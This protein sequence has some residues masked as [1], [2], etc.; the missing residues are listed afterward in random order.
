MLY[1]GL[2]LAGLLLVGVW[3]GT[4]HL[5]HA[6]LSPGDSPDT[7]DYAP[8][9]LLVI[10]RDRGAS[11]FPSGPAAHTPAAK[12][13]DGAEKV[14][15]DPISITVGAFTLAPMAQAGQSTIFTVD[16]PTGQEVA[17]L[18]ALSAEPGVAAVS[19]DYRRHI[20]LTPDDPSFSAKQWNMR[21]IN[22]PLAWD[23]TTGSPK[24]IIAVAD[25]GVDGTHPDL[26][27]RLVG[28]INT[29][30]SGDAP[31][32]D[33]NGHGTHVAS[34]AAGTGNDGV[35]IAGVDWQAGIMPVKVLDDYGYGYDSDIVVG[36]L[37]AVDNGADILNV[38]WGS[39]YDST[40]L[41]EA[42]AYA[43]Q[44]G[45]TVV[46]AA[47]NEFEFGNPVTYPAAFPH[48]IA[49]AAVDEQD[50]HPNF[51]SAG[52]FVDVA[53]PGVDIFAANPLSSYL[54]ETNYRERSGTS[55]A[56]PH[57]TGQAALLYS[58]LPNL[59][60]ERV[61]DLITSSTKDL[62][63]PGWDAMSGHGLID[64]SQS[65]AQG[66][67]QSPGVLSAVTNGTFDLG[68]NGAWTEESGF[69]GSQGSLIWMGSN[70]PAGMKPHSG[71]HVAWL[72][73]LNNETS[74]LSQ[75]ISLTQTTMP[76]T[77]FY[78]IDS[79][80]PCGGDTATFFQNDQA[81]AHFDLC[82]SSDT[83]GWVQKQ[84]TLTGQISDTIMLR[85]HV[86]T[87]RS[88]ISSFL[89]D[90]VFL[91]APPPPPTQVAFVSP[92]QPSILISH[93]GRVRM[94]FPTGVVSE[95][96]MAQIDM[97]DVLGRSTYGSAY[98]LPGFTVR[99]WDSLGQP[100]IRT[101]Q[102]VTL[103]FTYQENDWQA[104]GI[105]DENRLKLHIWEETL[106]QPMGLCPTCGL[107]T[108]TN[109]IRITLDRP[110]QFVVLAEPHRVYMPLVE[111]PPSC[112]P[113]E[114]P[115]EW[116]EAFPICLNVPVRGTV[117]NYD[118]VDQ[119]NFYADAY[120]T[121]AITM[122]DLAKHGNA[123]MFLHPPNTSTA[124][125]DVVDASYNYD[126]N[127]RIRGT[128]LVSG[129]WALQI[130]NFSSQTAHYEVVVDVE[131]PFPTPPCT[132][133]LTEPTSDNVGAPVIC[134]HQTVT[135]Q[136]STGT[137][138]PQPYAVYAVPL[139]MGQ[140]YRFRLT[141]ETGDADL[142]LFTPTESSLHY[143]SPYSWSVSGES[144]EYIE[145]QALAGG[146]WYI[147]VY[148]YYGTTDYTLTFTSDYIASPR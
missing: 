46:A 87:D 133:D 144:D 96:I 64:V 83:D 62:F 61:A 125:F 14:R 29:V 56:A 126:S 142:Y 1:V 34:I 145:G 23:L 119:F 69:F 132:P 111:I 117:G 138:E 90:D 131:G 20:F 120:H 63:E 94:D 73:G 148:S 3:G 50:R 39:S 45:V 65:I 40:V 4:P 51:S 60:P 71:G 129:T 28:G 140:Q 130:R 92:T 31:P 42:F 72:G 67:D 77:F 104:A 103:T 112:T 13:V 134:P 48:V 7:Q 102:P 35:G 68:P 122:T 137:I 141:G 16:V 121:I 49:V 74:D 88:Q 127:E 91:I 26:V 147:V 106:W 55:M 44:Q 53:A 80:A 115:G 17:A 2:I 146:T 100:I 21:H 11:A 15:S 84:I 47:G 12:R 99:F 38:S 36:I 135:G 37:W 97:Q 76:L 10:M 57:V 123:D 82:A 113:R 93:D 30:Y 143:Q 43:H 8:G 70:L 54:E 81:A 86:E 78:Q 41:R 18:E 58:V 52:H 22:A 95:T 32:N 114:D 128:T 33:S 109:Q 139:L 85:F 66:F 118:L 27:G 101:N 9:R 108:T 124:L 89:L 75:A 110:G 25:T 116:S 105:T 98:L 59:T 6:S 107:D 136:V 19:L 79:A 24:V 5:L